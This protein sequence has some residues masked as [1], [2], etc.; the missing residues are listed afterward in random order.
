LS[1]SD[2]LII[3]TFTRPEML[4]NCLETIDKCPEATT[5]DIIISVDWHEEKKPPIQEIDDV[6]K[7]FP[8][9]KFKRVAR[10]PHRYNG[11]S[12]NVL[13]AYKEA[14][15]TGC[16]HIFMVEDDVMVDPNFFGWHYQQQKLRVFCSVGVENKR[17]GKQISATDYASLGVCFPR[18][19]VEQIVK[20]ASHS[21]YSDQRGYC[22]KNF[23]ALFSAE[24]VEQDGL[25]LR[26]MGSVNGKS[27]WPE[28]PVCRHIGWY[29]YHRPQ[30]RPTGT[31]QER[32][33][34]VKARSMEHV[35]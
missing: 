2:V 18:S 12:F 21:Y 32:Y 24:D 16:N 9:L 20:H 5:L 3:P 17:S 19:A 27:V 15:Q 13:S 26:V 30:D 10:W 35:N 6:L 31:L 29:G 22:N 11:N 4:W 14:V 25:I 33:E 34:A 1:K 23:G 28:T 7:K 8:L